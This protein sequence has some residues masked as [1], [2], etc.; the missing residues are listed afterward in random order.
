MNTAAKANEIRNR[1]GRSWQ[2]KLAYQKLNM[3]WIMGRQKSTENVLAGRPRR[4]GEFRVA[5]RAASPEVLFMRKRNSGDPL[6]SHGG[7]DRGSG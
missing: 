1:L 2:Q 6:L 4:S 5:S 3:Q 7:L